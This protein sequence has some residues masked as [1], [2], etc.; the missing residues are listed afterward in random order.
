MIKKKKKI[1]S[2]KKRKNYKHNKKSSQFLVRMIQSGTLKEINKL[3]KKL[4][5]DLI[6]KS[7]KDGHIDGLIVISCDPNNINA[8]S[9]YGAAKSNIPVTGSGGS[10]LATAVSKY[11]IKLVGNSGGSVATTTYTRSIS[12]VYSLSIDWNVRYTPFMP[13][14]T[15]NN[16]NDNSNSMNDENMSLPNVKSVLESCL[17]AFLIVSIICRLLEKYNFDTDSNTS[18]LLS[19]SSDDLL[20][21]LKYQ[22]LPVVACVVFATSQ[23]PHQGS[24]VLM[25]SALA[26]CTSCSGSVLAGL[27]AGYIVSKLVDRALF[28]CIIW[29]IPATM[30]N[31]LVAGG[32]GMLT[33]LLFQI[34]H[35][36]PLCIALTNTL[37]SYLQ[38]TPSYKSWNG[39]GFGFLFG[40]AFC[41]SSKVGW[42][43]SILLPI[44]LLEMEQGNPSLFGSIDE[45]TLVLV[46]AGI[47][48]GHIILYKMHPTKY[49]NIVNQDQLVIIKRGF[50][51]NMLCGD[52]IEVVYPYMESYPIINTFGYIASG[53]STE[54]LY[55]SSILDDNIN[56]SITTTP[57]DVLSS[58]YVPI[59]ISIWLANDWFRMLCACLSAFGI[60]FF[61]TVLN[62][63]FVVYVFGSTNDGNK[64]KQK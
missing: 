19:F 24:T 34:S 45:C 48:F 50:I 38:T 37:R 47:C 13:L 9:I 22:T 54:I 40:C 30:S 31:I 63:V 4:D 20:S 59:F 51:I 62:Y 55:G 1:K 14:S 18:F 32:I 60:S 17:P 8:K 3:Y 27:L 39:L 36:T 61:G 33:S 43:H 41:Y 5:E 49:C 16:N 21:L 64:I 10:S 46:S 53:V 7:I 11:G 56:P 2:V 44:I 25:S 26:A 15:T 28:T 52:F 57:D 42:Y 35:I 12:Y 58:A 29:K 6:A 23:A